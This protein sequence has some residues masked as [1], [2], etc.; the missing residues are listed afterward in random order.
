MAEE[1][2]C[3]RDAK[4]CVA[5]F[6]VYVSCVEDGGK[7]CNKIMDDLENN[8]KC[9]KSWLNNWKNQHAAGKLGKSVFERLFTAQAAVK[10]A[11]VEAMRN[12][13]PIDEMWTAPVDS[14]FPNQN[15][16][17]NCY[18]NFLDYHRCQRF[19]DEDQKDQCEYF[20]KVYEQLCFEEWT[21]KWTDQIEEGNFAGR[22]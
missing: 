14:R 18:Q 3:E 22:I 4:D 1:A 15:Q 17:K 20:K 19:V 10:K 7:D 5:Q 13:P 16:I 9:P 2:V 12:E 6:A 8:S 11:K 21:D